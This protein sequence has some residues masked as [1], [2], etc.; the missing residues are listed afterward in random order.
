MPPLIFWGR[1]SERTEAF[2]GSLSGGKFL[3]RVLH[4]LDLI[5][6]PRDIDYELHL[7][8]LIAGYEPQY[9]RS[10]REL[11]DTRAGAQINGV[12]WQKF[13]TDGLID[14]PSG[15]PGPIKPEL[16]DMIRRI[17]RDLD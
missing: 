11:S 7:R 15:G 16:R 10:L 17:L 6:S 14:H 12:H 4:Q 9:R 1:D 13:K 3:L 2:I 5:I 8:K